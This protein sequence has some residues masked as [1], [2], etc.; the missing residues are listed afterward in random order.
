M[1]E[2]NNEMAFSCVRMMQRKT[3]RKIMAC[4]SSAL[5]SLRWKRDDVNKY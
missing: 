1:M 4:F 2:I 5:L 3:E